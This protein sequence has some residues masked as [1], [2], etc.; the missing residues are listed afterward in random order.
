MLEIDNLGLKE[1]VEHGIPLEI[2]EARLRPL[3]DSS[4]RVKELRRNDSFADF[5]FDG[6]LGA[7]ESLL[8]VVHSDW[9]VVEQFDTGHKEIAEALERAIEAKKMP[10]R[11]YRLRLAMVTCGGQACPWGCQGQY[12]R[13]SMAFI[14]Y[15]KEYRKDIP[16]MQD[17][18]YTGTIAPDA[19]REASLAR[20]VLENKMAVVT[21][22][23]PHLIGEHYFFEG[24]ESPYRADPRVLIEA[25][26]MT[27][28]RT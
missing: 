28:R 15:D 27:M 1:L 5:S 18:F 7:G 9:L 21:E 4:D 16:T 3:G 25:L 11:K 10:N 2:L 20:R 8:E 14:I 13:A 22:I 23:H 24:R 17:L 19:A 26:G 6:F 12:K